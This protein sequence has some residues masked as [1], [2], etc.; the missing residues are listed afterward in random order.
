MDLL[1]KFESNKSKIFS[2][3]EENPIITEE[4]LE[5]KQKIFNKKNFI[6][7][8]S[9]VSKKKIFKNF[10]KTLTDV[11]HLEDFSNIENLSNSPTN[12]FNNYNNENTVVFEPNNNIYNPI[13]I[14]YEAKVNYILNSNKENNKN[15]KKYHYK[16]HPHELMYFT[17]TEKGYVPGGWYCDVCK[18]SYEKNIV[19]LHCKKCGW[20]V[21]DT[22]Y[23]SGIEYLE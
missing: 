22:C 14:E 21:C 20:D 6:E 8:S 18:K 4:K 19:N 3:S 15:K 10:D 23:S 2:S 12:F 5:G 1:Y 16:E 13:N 17:Y 7:K 9:L 11:Y